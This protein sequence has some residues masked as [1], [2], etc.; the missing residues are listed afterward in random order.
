MVGEKWSSKQEDC[1][2]SRMEEDQD[3]FSFEI[4]KFKMPNRHPSGVQGGGTGWKYNH[5]SQQCIDDV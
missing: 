4:V 2:K 1:G 5:G 3:G